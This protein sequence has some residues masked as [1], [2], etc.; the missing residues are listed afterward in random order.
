ML[1]ASRHPSYN[2][3][4]TQ[5]VPSL[6]LVP[7]GLWSENYFQAESWGKGRYHFIVLLPWGPQFCTV[8]RQDVLFVYWGTLPL[9]PRCSSRG[10]SVGSVDAPNLGREFPEGWHHSQPR[11]LAWLSDGKQNH[12]RNLLVPQTHKVH[13]STS[14][15]NYHSLGCLNTSSNRLPHSTRGSQLGAQVLQEQSHPDRAG[16]WP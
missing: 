8:W 11:C 6:S 14:H 7:S 1:A 15:H 16:E 13:Q 2:L 4:S 3:P 9:V 5:Q 12:L 10:G